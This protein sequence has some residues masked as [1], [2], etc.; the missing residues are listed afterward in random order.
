MLKKTNKKDQKE[1]AMRTNHKKNLQCKTKRAID[2]NQHANNIAVVRC[3]AVL[4][5][6]ALRDELS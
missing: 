4:N 1:K 2:S 5:S 6:F 3:T